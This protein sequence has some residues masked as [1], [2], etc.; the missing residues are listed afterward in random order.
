[1]ASDYSSLLRFELIAPGE[2]PGL[3]GNTA[4]TNLGT[5]IEQAIAGVTTVTLSNNT[6]YVLS[7]TNGT[8]DEQR[9][10]VIVVTGTPGGATNIVVPATQKWWII[11]NGT[12]STLTIKT[13]GQAG[14]PTLSTG[15]SCFF[16]CDG[17]SVYYGLAGAEVGNGGT[18]STTAAGART[19]LGVPALDGTGAT[20][21]WP[22]SITGAAGSATL[23]TNG[24]YT[25]DLSTSGGANKVPRYN[26]V[27]N[28]GIGATVSGLWNGSGAGLDQDPVFGMEVGAHGA[29]SSNHAGAGSASEFS[30]PVSYWTN[31]AYYSSGWKRK[32]VYA[33][34]L[35]N[36]G[37]GGFF[38]FAN[39]GAGSIDGAITWTTRFQV[40]STGA[41]T[42]TGTY[43]TTSDIRLKTD[44]DH[45]HDALA[46]VLKLTGYTY[47][48]IENPDAPR[49]MG[50]IA[51]NVREVAPEVVSE[52][53]KML[54]VAYPN[55]VALLVEAIKEL[56]A[57]VDDL[58]RQVQRS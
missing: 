11:K 15:N 27:G 10:A 22:I 50:L 37:I 26:A 4:N 32:G 44:F 5:L 51:Q 17:T 52:D 12:P 29:L 33:T 7:A 31:S 41:V 40:S 3:W 58:R 16:Y 49:E 55:L 2:Q 18:G 35:T 46:K 48:R 13:S 21:T 28:I 57:E 9:S 30:T 42:A 38:Q 23:V 43:S 45:I 47:K 36:G 53:D 1:M 20:G 6:D 24:V 25:T 39:S 19:N 8:P 54:T 14:A 34:R 56:K